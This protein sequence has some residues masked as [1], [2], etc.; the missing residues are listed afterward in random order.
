[1][2]ALVKQPVGSQYFIRNLKLVSESVG[3]RAQNTML[4]STPSEVA[5]YMSG[6]FDGFP[7]Q[8]RVWVVLLNCRNRPIGRQLVTVGTATNALCAARECFR[9]AIIGGATAIV[10]VHN[11][12]SGDPTP[13]AADIRFTR[14]MMDSG[15]VVD[16]NVLDHV[17]I[18]EAIH[19]PCGRG[20]YSFREAGMC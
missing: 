16:I 15:K 20:I 11:H 6:A 10:L 19:D 4:A 9:G 17:I 1:M 13:S 18:G 8:E 14:Q 2:S 7:D 3:E 12:P 5:S